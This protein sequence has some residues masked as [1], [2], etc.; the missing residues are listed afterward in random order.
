[1]GA[2]HHSEILLFCHVFVLFFYLVF[3]GLI[4]IL[5]VMF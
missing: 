3:K 2:T 5:R 1:L 4:N